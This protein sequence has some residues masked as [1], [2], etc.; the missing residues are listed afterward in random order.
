MKFRVLFLF[1]SARLLLFEIKRLGLPASAEPHQ[2]YHWFHYQPHT[3]QLTRLD[4]KALSSNP[5]FEVREF[6]QGTLRFSDIEGVY[7]PAPDG[8]PL[9]AMHRDFLPELPAP[10]AEQLRQVQ[11]P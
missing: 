10:V 1:S 3:H 5:P 11:L 4:F 7:R 6:A 9:V 8:T 2:L